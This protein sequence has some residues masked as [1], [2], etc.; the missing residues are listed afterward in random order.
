[1]A[2]VFAH[3]GK[4][5]GY[6]ARQFIEQGRVAERAALALE[7]YQAASREFESFHGAIG[8]ALVYLI[9]TILTAG[10]YDLWPTPFTNF[11]KRKFPPGHI[12]WT[13]ITDRT[14]GRQRRREGEEKAR[15]K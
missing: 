5:A 15:Q 11:L 3:G 9:V 12:F 6:H 13:Y 10:S 2:E 14:P 1:V 8:A 4:T 7:L